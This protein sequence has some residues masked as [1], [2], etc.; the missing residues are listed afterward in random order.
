MKVDRVTQSAH[1]AALLQAAS[2]LFR[3]RGVD[4]VS[5]AEVSAAAGLTHGAF[6]GHYASKTALAAAALRQA[7]VESA[8]QWRRRAATARAAG[9]DPLDAIIDGYLNARHRDEPGGG[10]ALSAL[11]ADAGRESQAGL[12][13]PLMEMTESLLGVL[14]AERALLHPLEPAEAHAQAA[15]GAL[16][17]MQGGM[18]LARLQS[19]AAPEAADA[20]LRAARVAARRALD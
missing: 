1:R 13:A 18:V 17:A 16:A 5:V 11:S 3:A 4:R 14:I 8:E 15:R 12:A 20:M 9:K 19:R 6:Y 10:C 2:R 7:A